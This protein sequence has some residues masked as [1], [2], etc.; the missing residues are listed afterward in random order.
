[1]SASEEF[2]RGFTLIAYAN[3]VATPANVVSPAPRGQGT[4]GF[5]ITDIL[6]SVF[7]SQATAIDWTS[8]IILQWPSGTNQEF[9]PGGPLLVN[10]STISAGSYTGKDSLTWSGKLYV[11]PGDSFGVS[12]T[13]GATGVIQYLQVGGYPI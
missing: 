6:A 5:V 11:P 3:N 4:I 10:Q 8:D 9:L 2:P 12:F 13:G 7:I 1:M